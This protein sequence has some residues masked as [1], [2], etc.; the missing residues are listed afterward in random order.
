MSTEQS[1]DNSNG[2][3]TQDEP[4][5]CE[6][7]TGRLAAGPLT[8]TVFALLGGLAVWGVLQIYYPLVTVPDEIYADIKGPP[9]KEK[10]EEIEVAGT[11]AAICNAIC[12]FGLFGAI[13][14]GIMGMGEGIARRCVA[15]VLVAAIVVGLA[16]VL[17]GCLA[18]YLGNLTMQTRRPGGGPP[19]LVDSLRTHCII[20]TTLGGGIGIGLGILTGRIKTIALCL[21]SGTLAGALAATLFTVSLAAFM[22]TVRTEEIVPEETAARV[23]WIALSSGLLGLT[24]S[25]I[26]GK[27]RPK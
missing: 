18:G 2:A 17:F 7:G 9:S 10:V 26:A 13:V 12:T 1:G 4:R 16:G 25:A 22:P 23:L 20:L 14:G 15:R 24:I 27:P 5:P 3:E 21:I 8:G 19:G 6:A 11:K